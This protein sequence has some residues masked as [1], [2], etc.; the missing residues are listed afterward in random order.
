[1]AGIKSVIGERLIAMTRLLG[2]ERREPPSTFPPERRGF[3]LPL[4][5]RRKVP[6]QTQIPPEHF[7]GG[8]APHR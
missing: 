2:L 4:Q 6:R 1:M 7:P 3:R 8:G 5:R